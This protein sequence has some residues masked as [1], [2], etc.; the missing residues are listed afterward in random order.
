MNHADF[1]LSQIYKR[2]KSDQDIFAEL[3]E[4]KVKEVLL[5][6]NYYDAY[7]IVREGRFFDRIYG[8]F[9]Q[10]NLYTAPRITSASNIDEALELM[11]KRHFDMV[12]LMAGLDKK[13]TY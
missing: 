3:M 1:E 6:A 2:K 9:L 7:S 5:I 12:I 8:E 13:N 11:G 10:L 4:F